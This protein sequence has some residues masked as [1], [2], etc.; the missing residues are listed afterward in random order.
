MSGDQDFPRTPQRHQGEERIT[1]CLP[2]PTVP[3]VQYTLLLSLSFHICK[4]GLTVVSPKQSKQ[5][6]FSYSILEGHQKDQAKH[7]AV[8][9][10]AS[11]SYK[12]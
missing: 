6:H 12:I 4:L 9:F 5:S 11:G 8:L 3:C 10:E 2:G 1:P 7:F